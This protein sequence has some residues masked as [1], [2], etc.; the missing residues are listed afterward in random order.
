V[1][2][3]SWNDARAFCNW[4]SEKEGKKCGLPTEAQW[5]Y[6]CRAGSRTKFYFGDDDAKLDQYAWQMANSQD[7]THPVGQKKPNVWGLY[8]MHG[9]VWQ[10]MA[11]YYAPDY[12]QKSPREDPPGPSAGRDIAL[13]GGSWHADAGHFSAARRSV[14]PPLWPSADIGFRVVRLR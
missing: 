5:E 8:D 3:V 12:Y 6:A 1:V 10:W 2:C 14:L 7:Q 4:L 13:R 11:N 9:N